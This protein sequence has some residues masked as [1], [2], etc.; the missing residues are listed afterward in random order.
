MLLAPARLL[1]GLLQATLAILLLAGAPVTGRARSDHGGLLG[2]R[3]EV[4]LKAIEQ[5]RD[6]ADL[7]AEAWADMGRLEGGEGD[8]TDLSTALLPSRAWLIS[9]HAYLIRVGR[10]SYPTAPPSQWPC[11]APP[12]GPPLA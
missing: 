9:D 6:R 4:T 2:A 12:T 3:T 10:T 1:I 7:D 5:S 8:D 11:A